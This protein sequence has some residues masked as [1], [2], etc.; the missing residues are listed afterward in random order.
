MRTQSDF[1]K[2]SRWTLDS[3]LKFQEIDYSLLIREYVFKWIHPKIFT[4]ENQQPMKKITKS[5]TLLECNIPT[6]QNADNIWHDIDIQW[7]RTHVP[8]E[9]G[10]FHKSLWHSLQDPKSTWN[11]QANSSSQQV[12]HEQKLPS[13]LHYLGRHIKCIF[14]ATATWVCLTWR[15][16]TGRLA[17][18]VSCWYLRLWPCECLY[19]H[20]LLPSFPVK[21]STCFPVVIYSCSRSFG[22][23][24]SLRYAVISTV[25]CF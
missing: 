11:P 25:K 21:R 4:E 8:K 10:W 17:Q 13:T 7:N 22:T 20:L 5:Q 1:N 9:I 23:W 14:Y 16:R 15:Y 18:G 19:L 6:N 3:L 24:A 12:R 2:T